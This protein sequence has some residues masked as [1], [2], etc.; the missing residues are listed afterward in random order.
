MQDISKR[1]QLC[2]VISFV[3]EDSSVCENF[4]GLKDLSD[5]GIEYN[6]TASGQ[7]QA[8]T[9]A[10][11]EKKSQVDYYVLSGRRRDQN[12]WWA[13]QRN[14]KISGVLPP[15]CCKGN[16][17]SSQPGLSCE[18]QLRVPWELFDFFANIFGKNQIIIFRVLLA[19]WSRS[20]KMCRTKKYET[21]YRYNKALKPLT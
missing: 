12:Q 15:I 2:L 1:S 17:Q 10:L 4:F 20:T 14:K 3:L 19:F 8:L 11:G 16:M 7:F 21:L 5:I 13:L 18:T 6:L 9:D